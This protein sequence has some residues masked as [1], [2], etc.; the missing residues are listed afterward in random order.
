VRNSSNGSPV[1]LPGTTLLGAFLVATVGL[2]AW[3]AYQA[4]DTARSHRRTAEAT[5]RD[6][7]GISAW[8]LSRRARDNLDE[9]LDETFDPV[10]RR[11]RGD[12]LPA[13]EVVG[14]GMDDAARDQ[15]CRCRAFREPAALFRVVLPAGDLSFESR[16]LQTAA[17]RRIT[18]DI[19]ARS[20]G[21]ARR[22]EG[23][24]VVPAAGIA[25]QP[26]VVGYSLTRSAPDLEG[27]LYGFVVPRE[28]MTE[29]FDAWYRSA[30]LLPRPIAGDQP[31]DSLLAVSVRSPE[32]VEIFTSPAAYARTFAASDTL[33]AAF[34]G[35]VVEAAIRPDA[36]SQLVIGGLPR[37]RLPLLVTLLLLTLGVGAAALFQ[38]RRE[39]ALA[40]L[41]DDFISGV[42]HELRTPLAQIRMFAEL[43]HA[44]V[45]SSD[46]D[47]A[48]AAGVINREARRLTHL[49]ENILQ[50][51]RL[52]RT[53]GDGPL[54]ESVD[55]DEVL[56]E[57]F[58]A[59]EPLAASSSAELSVLGDR[60]MHVRANRAAVSQILGN[61]LDNALKYGP[62][63]QT[64]TVRVEAEDSVVRFVV[65][66][67]GPGIPARDRTRIWEPYRRLPRDVRSR[68]PGTGIG[69]AVVARLVRLH[70]G[71]A[72]VED[73]PE[74]GAR[75][76]VGLPRAV[77][78]GDDR[79]ESAGW[80]RRAEDAATG[81]KA[82]SSGAITSAAGAKTDATGRVHAPGPES[83]VHG[84]RS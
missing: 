35:L 6:H 65:D 7:A 34:G 28:A 49:V 45:L 15:R 40:Q 37:S 20:D 10:Y 44:G 71:H 58:E 17:L 18:D 72:R 22:R 21:P 9:V 75:F 43:Q 80:P 2:S 31:N 19:L 82:S 29:F 53:S 60:G 32:G 38:I 14:W 78:Q 47:R 55:V 70:G 67:Q 81:A 42:S 33:G 74:G 12:H 56:A 69:L 52:R 1:R 50:Y 13:A 11:L 64:L 4:I 24:L 3:L 59:V 61:L 23:F 77:S 84:R 83:R 36:A 16:D 27:V 63:G 48:R 39:R 46:P 51:S 26:Q 5:L 62:P 41:R 76:I 57:S 79:S 25:G 30:H 8:E 66:D 54:T 68:L 73:A